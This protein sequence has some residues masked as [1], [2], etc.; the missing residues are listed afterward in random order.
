MSWT[1]EQVLG[2]APD[3]KAAKAGRGQSSPARWS[4]L[5]KSDRALWGLCQGSGAKP[6]ETTVDLA[7]PAFRC[8]CPSRKF[9]CKHGLGLMLLWAQAPGAIPAGEPPA[10]AG[11]WL[12]ARDDRAAKRAEPTSSTAAD[13]EEAAAKAAAAAQRRAEQREHRIAAGLD[14]LELWL[15]DL[16][17]RGFAQAEQLPRSH[18]E[19]TARRMVDAQAPG[20]ARRVRELGALIGSGEEWPEQALVQVGALHLLIAA[21]RRQNALDGPLR[22]E[23]RAQ[24]GW[25]MSKEDAVA[26]ERVADRWNVVGQSHSEEDR[27]RVRRT[28]LQGAH[29]ERWGLLLDFAAANQPLP[30]GPATGQAVIGALAY[31]PGAAPVRAL[32]VRQDSVAAADGLRAAGV[33][34]AYEQRAQ[35]LA[36]N[37]FAERIPI[38]AAGTLAA[39]RG[40]WHLAGDGGSA[41]PLHPAFAPSAAKL[42]AVSGGEAVAVFGE[43]LRDGLLPMSA[44]IDGEVLPL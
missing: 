24:V 42:L 36:R 28:W 14:E 35:T 40:R 20:L 12:S 5:G 11:E 26:G 43:W 10:W 38:A 30:P 44:C 17:R 22:A 7:E 6:Y 19:E 13:P 27:L 3:E 9:P 29:S 31:Y 15:G 1:P 25:S 2:L 23:V 8:S 18:Y 21:Y 16:V 33:D 41:L 4:S 39:H 34:A 37:P 32:V